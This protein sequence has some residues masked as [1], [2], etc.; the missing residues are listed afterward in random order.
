MTV[1]TNINALRALHSAATA[2]PWRLGIDEPW[3]IHAPDAGIVVGRT[4]LRVEQHDH[5]NAEFIVAIRNALPGL[6]DELSRLRELRNA[7]AECDRVATNPDGATTRDMADALAGLSVA[8][9]RVRSD[10]EQA[11]EGR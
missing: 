9:D 2:G 6:L 11:V 3:T 8:F 5:K 1:S 10:Y 7:A 4:T